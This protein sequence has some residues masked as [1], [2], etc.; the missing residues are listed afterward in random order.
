[1][2]RLTEV[3]Q[4]EPDR[5]D[6]E[7]AAL[8]ATREV[9]AARQELVEYLTGCGYAIREQDWIPWHLKLSN[10]RTADGGEITVADHE[11]CG[12]RAVTIGLDFAWRDDA[13]RDAWIAASHAGDDEPGD[14]GE[15]E[16]EFDDDVEAIAAGMVP[17]W[18][19]TGHLCTDPG[20]FGHA[21]AQGRIA[22]AGGDQTADPADPGAAARAEA[23]RIERERV[24]K[25]ADLRRT[26]VRN[27]A[28]R[29]ATTVRR[30]HVAA[31]L[32][33]PKLAPVKGRK[34]HEWEKTLR[35]AAAL[36]RARAIALHE[37]TPE[38]SSFGHRTA[39]RLLGLDGGEWD[40]ERSIINAIDAASPER[41]E[42]IEL[43]VVLGAYEHGCSGSDGKDAQTWKAAEGHWHHRSAGS[44]VA[45]QARY[46]AWLRDC[47]GYVL[48]DIENEVMAFAYP[49]AAAPADVAPPRESADTG[50]GVLTPEQIR[51]YPPGPAGRQQRINDEAI[52]ADADPALDAAHDGDPEGDPEGEWDSEDS[53]RYQDA[54]DA[55]MTEEQALAEVAARAADDAEAL[56]GMEAAGDDEQG[57]AL[58]VA[59]TAGPGDTGSP[60]RRRVAVS[61]TLTPGPPPA[62]PVPSFAKGVR[63][64]RGHLANP[65][66][67]YL[68]T[69]LPTPGLSL[70]DWRITT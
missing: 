52:A 23:D 21:D 33:R 4:D 11:E 39:A 55:G 64:G 40:L 26:K 14:P 60:G 36:L 28:W 53:G 65:R 10:L 1:M 57:E 5:F 24:K 68:P 7:L 15:V 45:G 2:W 20:Q 48:S 47:T 51:D 19:I 59:G 67:A 34:A 46:L 58:A 12:G 31:L 30:R 66:P 25:L 63:Y 56:A 41:A 44:E 32:S 9:R 35:T 50:A 62:C 61:L 69:H 18:E 16:V 37:T 70:A 54:L 17:V 49:P 8:R 27:T 43:G 6:H 3:A 13:A 38:M 29:A 22:A 42:V